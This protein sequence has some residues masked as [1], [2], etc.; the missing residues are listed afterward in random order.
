MP[1]KLLRCPFRGYGPLLQTAVALEKA[2]TVLLV[3]RSAE[4]C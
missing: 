2:S 1:A 3:C 4:A